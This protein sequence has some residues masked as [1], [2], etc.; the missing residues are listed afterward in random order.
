MLRE[1]RRVIKLF[2]KMV[3]IYQNCTH[4]ESHYLWLSNLFLRKA[5]KSNEENNIYEVYTNMVSTLLSNLK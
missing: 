4:S 5:F 3:H 2:L 1:R